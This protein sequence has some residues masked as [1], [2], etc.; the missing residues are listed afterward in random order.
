MKFGLIFFAST[1]KSLQER[2]KYR[3]IVECARFGDANGFSTVWIPERH[4]TQFGCLYPNPSVIHAA[5]ARETKH[6]RLHAGSVVMPL[7]NPLRV[8][9]EWAVVDNLSGGRAGISFAP[10]WNPDDFA[11]GP[12]KYAT[13]NQDMYAGID[14]VRRLWAGESL[15]LEN[16]NGKEIAVRVYP[17]PIQKEL[18]VWVTAASNP[19]SFARAGEIGANLLTH[20]LDHDVAQLA[21][22]IACYRAARA[23][24]GFH[25]DAGQ[26]TVL[27]HTYVGADAD[28][29]REQARKP[30]CN[31]M[32][33]NMHLF[34]GL[35]QSRGY[36]LDVHAMPEADQDDFT[37]FLF[38]RFAQTRGLIG[39]PDS[40]LPLVAALAQAGVDELACLLDFGPDSDLILESLP[41]LDALRKRCEGTVA[42]RPFA[43]ADGPRE[44]PEPTARGTREAPPEG[45]PGTR[46]DALPADD[47][48]AIR[49]RCP[50]FIPQPEFYRMLQANGAQLAGAFRSVA[51]IW[52]RDG[53]ALGQIRLAAGPEAAFG[54]YQVPPPLLDACFQVFGASLPLDVLLKRVDEAYV[55]LPVGFKELNVYGPLGE[56]VWSHSYLRTPAANPPP[57]QYEGDVRIMDADGAVLMKISGLRLQRVPAA[58][59]APPEPAPNWCYRPDWEPA[60]ETAQAE[61]RPAIPGKWL[62]FMDTYG[63]GQALQHRLEANGHCCIAV[64]PGEAWTQT[65]PGQYRVNPRRPEDFRQLVQAVQDHG[66]LPLHR[67]LYGWASYADLPPGT[68]ADGLAAGREV[69]TAGA[70]HLVQALAKSAVAGPS[71]LWFLT[72]SAQYVPAHPAPP[73]VAQ[74]ALWGLGRVAAVEFPQWWGGLADADPAAAPAATAGQLLALLGDPG[75]PAAENQLAF[76]QNQAYALRLNRVPAKPEPAPDGL[77]SPDRTYL[78]TGGAGGLGLALAQWMAGAGARNLVLVGREPSG[79][80]LEEALAALGKRQCRVEVI[81]A[82]VA[83][84]ADVRRLLAGIEKSLPA[85]GGIFH[86]AGMLDDEFLADQDWPRFEAAGAAKVAGAWNLHVHTGH[87]PLDF[88]VVFSSIASLVN[89]ARQGSYAAANAFLDALVQL[90][91]HRGQAGLCLNWGPFGEVG[92]A[93]TA[94][95]RKAHARLAELGIGSLSPAQ[96]FAVLHAALRDGMD[97]VAVLDADWRQFAGADPVAGRSPLLVGLVGEEPPAPP[98]AGRPKEA[99]QLAGMVP[100]K[101]R[102]ALSAYLT[103]EVANILG[104][105]DAARLD[106]SKGFFDLGMDSLM[107]LTFKDRLQRGLGCP[108]APTVVF[109]YGTVPALRDYLLDQLF[110]PGEATPPAGNPPGDGSGDGDHPAVE[111]QLSESELEVLLN[112]ELD[113]WNHNE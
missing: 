65:G 31:Y 102:N 26:V 87:L 44:Q 51:G 48:P 13:R 84:E 33:G 2:D 90:R 113:S 96:G 34:K 36:E 24:A 57:R 39:T 45:P 56:Q 80:A 1:E 4:F 5:L 75:R 21:E 53:E 82:D 86:L 63:I 60:T 19:A 74:A 77:F 12:E 54:A 83:V 59:P 101:R 67:I 111:M 73:A 22:K 105:G 69:A 38:E 18:P 27:L 112:S 50:E 37:N 15:Q 58:R 97:Q 103:S 93:R 6:I 42:R 95:G 108:L 85:L 41:H 47:L 28:V 32:K 106:V 68:T 11:L 7:H 92:H 55:Y 52:R 10:G 43:G 78:I 35:A 109:K 107:A 40:C 49:A 79:T 25:P 110:P 20:T 99:L 62:L 14:K 88:F 61:A 94:Y 23:T 3:L 17:T 16:G 8:A 98:P 70:L 29:V 104:F 89:V 81:R 30:Y 100:G 66:P 71:L 91:R 76:R 72:R 46:P 9:E 64:H